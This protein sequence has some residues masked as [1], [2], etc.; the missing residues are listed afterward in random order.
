MSCK[1]VWLQLHLLWA[2]PRWFWSFP[3]TQLIFHPANTYMMNECLYLLWPD[4][5]PTANVAVDLHRFLITLIPRTHE[6]I[7]QRNDANVIQ[8]RAP[9]LEVK[10]KKSEL[11]ERVQINDEWGHLRSLVRGV[12]SSENMDNTHGE[13]QMDGEMMRGCGR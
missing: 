2:H 5:I 3:R 1:K 4:N 13:R 8:G 6:T 9:S 12:L 7:S 11:Y 10:K